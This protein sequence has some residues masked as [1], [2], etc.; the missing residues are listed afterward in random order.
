MPDTQTIV[1]TPGS[2]ISRPGNILFANSPYRQYSPR[3][4][5][6][7]IFAKTV[8]RIK[9]ILSQFEIRI[10][11]IFPRNRVNRPVIL[12]PPITVIKQ[13]DNLIAYEAINIML[14]NPKDSKTTNIKNK[15]Y[16]VEPE[17]VVR[18]SVR[19]IT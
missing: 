17:L 19:N 18:E 16:T 14:G 2:L 11:A 13:P 15:V 3:F 4:P 1:K 6:I 12:I 7:W 10:A 9:Y 5:D 8:R